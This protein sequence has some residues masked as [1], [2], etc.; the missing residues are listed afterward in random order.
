MPH[1]LINLSPDL[2]KLRDEGFEVEIRA[3]YL[4]INSVPYLN[5]N[6]EIKLGALVSELT[7]AGN[8]T[9]K[10]QNLKVMLFIL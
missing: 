6:K 4:L 10:Q 9:I 7:L 1:K 5:S 3:A 2:K 8:K